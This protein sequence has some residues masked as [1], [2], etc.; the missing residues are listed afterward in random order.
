ML[1]RRAL[2]LDIQFDVLGVPA[3]V[4]RPWPDDTAIETRGI[5]VTPGLTRPFLEA[6]P[7]EF[8]IQRRDRHRVIA[9]KVSDV[10]TVP[11]GTRIE[12][13]ERDGD[14]PLTWRVDGTEYADADHRRVVVVLETEP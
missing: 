12:M 8:D 7:S 14:D 13:A 4:T 10:P 11:K 2:A 3:T 5:W 9:L 6:V 1:E